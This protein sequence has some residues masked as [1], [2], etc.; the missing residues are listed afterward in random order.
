VT[1]GWRPTAPPG[2]LRARAAMLARI[3]AHFAAAGVLEV[4]TPT[5][6][7]AAVTDVHLASVPAEVAGLG[8]MYLHT[9]PEYAMK[10]LLAAGVGDCFQ[11]CR[12]YRD[13]EAGRWHNPEFTMVEWYRVGF[14]AAALMDDVEALVR[15]ALAPQR[16][17]AP[18]ERVT[19]RDAV[20]RH[21][22]VDPLDARPGDVAAALARHGIEAPQA[23]RDE[24]LDLLV[25]AVVGPALGRAGG[26]FVCDYPAS[27]AALARLKP[28]DPTV[29][30]RFELY[31]DGIELANGFH[32]LAD[33]REQRARFAADLAERTRRR[34]PAPPVD[35]RFL[36]ALESGIPDCSGVALGFDRLVMVALGLESLAAA[37]AFPADRA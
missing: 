35:E 21:G 7:R 15:S 3:R 4:E 19:Y 31:L 2:V 5:L 22:G 13:G 25:S 6:S 34:L 18:F 24:L 28:S 33:A 1:A 36:A 32:E 17:L 26:T 37:M 20:R 8:R 30:E 11:V 23:E 10:R 12:V 9:S 14:G 29:A 27:Q 16:A